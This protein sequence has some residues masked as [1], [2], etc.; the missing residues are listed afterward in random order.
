MKKLMMVALCLAVA[1]MAKA[2]TDEGAAAVQAVQDAAQVKVDQAKTAEAKVKAILD[3][4]LAYSEKVTRDTSLLICNK[5]QTL[6][7]KAMHAKRKGIP[8]VS[9][10]EF[11]ALN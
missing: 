7:G 1:G 3:R 5:T 8:I 10:A 2:E 11:L 6:R 9:D 4:D